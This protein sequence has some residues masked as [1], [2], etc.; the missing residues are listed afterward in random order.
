VSTNRKS[1]A[2]RINGAKSKGPKSAATR[3]KSS[4]NSLR[5]GLTACNTVVLAC[6]SPE[7]FDA[8][9]AK[10][11]ERLQPATS[12]EVDLV[13]TMIAAAWRIERL[14][15]IETALNGRRNGSPSARR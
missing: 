13:R 15:T 10:F 1:E 3:E 4:K 5:H 11:N 12:E 9:V 14:W 8:I 2:S 6:E 7:D